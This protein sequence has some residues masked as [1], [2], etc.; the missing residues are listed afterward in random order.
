MPRNFYHRPGCCSQ[1]LK[2]LHHDD[3]E[4]GCVYYY[5]CFKAEMTV[6]LISKHSNANITLALEYFD[7][8]HFSSK[9]REQIQ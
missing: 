3:P 1:G 4:F 7:E 8:S 6:K 2:F 5:K 9:T